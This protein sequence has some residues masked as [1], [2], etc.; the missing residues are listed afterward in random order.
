MIVKNES[1]IITRLLDSVSLLIDYY[2]ICDTGSTD[3]TISLIT[4]YFY[5]RN[6]EGVIYN[7]PFVNFCHNRNVSLN[8]CK[9]LSDYILL[10]DADMVLEIKDFDK[11]DL[12]LDSYHLSQGSEHFYYNNMR[13]IRNNGNYYYKGVTH[14]YI[15]TIENDKIGKIPKEKLFIRDHGDGGSKLNKFERDRELLLK[16]IEEEPKNDRY[17]FYLANTYRDLGDIDN[18]I[19][20]YKKRLLLGGWWEEM[21]V[22]CVELT[23]LIKDN[24]RFFYAVE[25]F[26]FNPKRV[27]GILQL[28]KHYTCEG[29]YTI[30]YNYYN[31]IKDYYEN[32]YFSGNGD[33][34]SNL[35]S[36]VMD[37]TF[38]LPY[39]M[40]IVCEHL[41]KWD[42]GILMY[43]IILKRKTLG[44]DWWMKNLEFNLQFYVPFMDSKLKNELYQLFNFKKKILFYV[45]FSTELW[46]ISYSETHALGGSE[47]AV[48]Y[49]AQC[50]A[51]DYSVYIGG[52]VLEETKNGV[53]FI[54]RNSMYSHKHFDIIV[55]SRYLSFFTL[56]PDIKSD[57]LYLMVHDIDLLNNLAGC[58]ISCSELLKNKKINNVICLTNWH[59]KC[60]QE[61]YPELTNYSIINNGINPSLFKKSF[62][63]KRNSFVFT[64][65][66]Y[67]GLKRLLEL[68]PEIISNLPDA[69]LSISSYLEFPNN[70]EDNEME[71]IIRSRSEIVHHG[72]LNRE[73]L[74]QLMEISEFWLYP[75]SFN[76]TSCITAIEMLM[77]E[78]ICLYYPIAGLTETIGEYGIQVTHGNEVENIL[79]LSEK[80]KKKIRQIGKEYALS[81][82]WENRAIQW[83]SLFKRYDFIFYYTDFNIIPLQEYL[84]N[85]G[86]VLITN[87]KQTVLDNPFSE[88]IIIYNSD[89][90]FENASLLNTEPLN[91]KLRLDNLKNQV[92]KYKFIYD[93]SLANINIMKQNGITGKHLPYIVTE[94]EK[95]NLI[96]LK[97]ETKVIYDFGIICGPRHETKDPEKLTPPRRKKVVKHLLKKYKINLISGWGEDRDRE[98][99]KCNILLNIHGE[100]NGEHGMIFEHLRCDRLLEAGYTIYSETSQDLPEN[101]YP[102]LTF[103]EYNDFFE[104]IL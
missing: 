33:I 46:N 99:A 60:I 31:F 59:K 97:K 102:N 45:G 50:L 76:E 7:E 48:C 101:L 56:F 70:D 72:K 40:I 25:S 32:E 15:C 92:N 23:K 85:L 91:I 37:Y 21:Y 87:D 81:C 51:K 14:E 9:G 24:T 20:Y 53:Q 2:V 89:H 38:F 19:I 49:L 79:E 11:N 41:K 42:T 43:R 35:F 65:C 80:Q 86:N 69:T 66:S 55:V 13:I 52:D 34:S 28:I 64:S 94:S 54:N 5:K 3:N 73:E 82:S 22:S 75:C 100:L 8:F 58:T 95:N 96:K 1:K 74:Y 93:Y 77:S 78:V 4:D 83:K 98:I 71:K 12:V 104:I 16:V 29:K 90:V 44:N 6:I 62:I 57:K 26:H 10:L 67:R 17:H 63:K 84:N 103:F 47:L 61:K 30:A 39:Y 18:A 27:E 88:I 36:I 68:W